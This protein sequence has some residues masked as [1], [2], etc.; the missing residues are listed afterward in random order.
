V[1]TNPSVAAW[2]C[3]N[4]GELQKS[5]PAFVIFKKFALQGIEIEI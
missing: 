5:F 2:G 3:Y 1:C 4:A